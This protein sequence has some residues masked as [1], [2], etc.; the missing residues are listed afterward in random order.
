MAQSAY[1]AGL[2][3]RDAELLRSPRHS[4]LVRVTHWV[5]ALSFV[6]SAS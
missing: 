3:V 2:S 6:G 4:L 5:H 1:L